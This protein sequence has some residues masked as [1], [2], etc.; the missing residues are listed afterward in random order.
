MPYAY[1]LQ[2]SR[3]RTPGVFDVLDYDTSLHLS[4]EE[5]HGHNA[6]PY[7]FGENKHLIDYRN[8]KKMRDILVDS[9][10]S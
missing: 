7:K 10:L 5:F 3:Y 4:I 2:T 1:L 8:K 6:A 9:F